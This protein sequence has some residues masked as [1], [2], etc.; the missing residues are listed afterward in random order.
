[1]HILVICCMLKRCYKQ[2]QGTLCM[3]CRV[4]TTLSSVGP[5][6]RFLLGLELFVGD[7]Y[8]TVYSTHVCMYGKVSQSTRV[9][10]IA[11]LLA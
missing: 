9:L 6:H 8:H 1:M 4:R 7:M 2:Y 10:Y 11:I 3:V 5:L